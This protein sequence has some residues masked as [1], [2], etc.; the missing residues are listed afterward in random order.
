MLQDA[1]PQSVYMSAMTSASLWLPVN[2]NLWF[3][4]ILPYKNKDWTVAQFQLGYKGFIQL[5]QRSGQFKTISASPVYEG[6]LVEENPLT[7]YVFDWKNKKSD[8]I[9]GYAWY[10]ALIN[11]FE[12]TIFMSV[13]ELKK[14]GKKYSQTYKKWFG[15]WETD[16]D[17]MATK[18]VIKLLLSKFAPLSVEMQTAM[19]VDQW[20]IKGDSLEDIEYLDNPEIIESE[21]TVNEELVA[22]WTDQLA[23]CSTIEEVEALYRQNKPT[24]PTILDLFSERKHEITSGQVQD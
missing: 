20:V 17:A 23:E 19:I 14:H 7:W 4:Y 12:K 8:S 13:E 1:D 3:A 2:P 22:N 21:V 5:A 15:L 18:T 11:W 9:V 16:F 6:Q 10:F 24:N